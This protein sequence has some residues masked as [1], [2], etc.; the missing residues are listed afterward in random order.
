M[1][2][3]ELAISVKV[4]A[5]SI[6][7]SP[8]ENAERLSIALSV[9]RQRDGVVA[10]LR[11]PEVSLLVPPPAIDVCVCAFPGACVSCL[12]PEGWSSSRSAE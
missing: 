5:A 2:F 10:L 4:C 6:A 1:T 11:F 3:F 7:L 8:C 9:A 12:G